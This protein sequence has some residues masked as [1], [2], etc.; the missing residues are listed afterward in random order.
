MPSCIVTPISESHPAL[1]AIQS[2]PAP[3]SP[4][5]P[6]PDADLDLDQRQLIE[7]FAAAD[8]RAKASSA[9]TCR[10]FFRLILQYADHWGR[11]GRTTCHCKMCRNCGSGKMRAHR[12]FAADP[13]RFM[14]MASQPCRTVR[15]TVP[16][17]TPAPNLDSYMARIRSDQ[18]HLR[19]LR[20]RL[21][22]FVPSSSPH[23][24]YPSVEPDPKMQNVSFRLYYVGGY[25]D[26][27][28][29]ASTWQQII[30]LGARCESRSWHKDDA[31]DA[32]RWTLNSLCDLLLLPAA[33][34]IP[35]ER[36]LESIRLGSP[37]G[38]LRGLTEA[39]DDVDTS[40]NTDDPAP[41]G[42]CPCKCGGVITKGSHE[43]NTLTHFASTIRQLSFGP[44]SDYAPYRPKG[45]TPAR[46]A[47]KIPPN[48]PSAT[49]SP[50]S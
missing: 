48:P 15:L 40:T 16:H 33:K 2:D 4:P 12:I 14:A 17:A 25:A 50:P 23:G 11:L 9:F 13:K 45:N 22:Q 18:R 41:Y 46:E 24:Y 26:H 42:Y 47:Y 10:S 36:A 39:G 21:R 31:K 49:S 44:L 35:W 38:C 34:R 43:P 7:G 20:R 1:T 3:W 5:I 6:W 8:M 37:V 19:T 27:Q 28:W 29:F 32:L 30:G